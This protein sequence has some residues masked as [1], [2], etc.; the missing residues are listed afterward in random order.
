MIFSC[1]TSRLWVGFLAICLMAATVHCNGEIDNTQDTSTSA[2]ISATTAVFF[3]T[4]FSSPGEL[5]HT[6]ADISSAVL[7]SADNSALGSEATLVADASGR[8]IVVHSGFSSFSSDNLT[9]LDPE[10]A[11][12]VTGQFST[13]SDAE[14]ALTN[15]NSAIVIDDTAYVALSNGN[16]DSENL[17]NAGN[18]ADLLVMDLADGTFL[19]RISFLTFTED[20]GDRNATPSAMAQAGD[21]IY[22]ALQDLQSDYSITAPGKLIAVDTTT[23]T[24]SLYATLQ[25]TNPYDLAYSESEDCLVVA[26][27][28]FVNFSLDTTTDTGG[29]ELV[30]DGETRAFI[31]D[32]DLD[33]YPE[34]LAVSDD[35]DTVF[36]VVSKLNDD[37]SFTSKIVTF[38]LSDF[39]AG[40]VTPELVTF[41]APETDIRDMVLDS[42][43]KLWVATREITE[44]EGSAEDPAV[45]VLDS[46]TGDL[47]AQ[48]PTNLAVTAIAFVVASEN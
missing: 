5:S 21:T 41:F 43:N 44:G 17:D 31:N 33:G 12:S 10:D 45:V 30:C 29:I 11:F 8:L 26:A 3:S 48:Y 35:L 18:P 13:H 28:Y 32:D 19:D 25:G 46:S 1:N 7:E 9:L 2:D 27:T 20:D 22:V 38:S 40:E 14:S 23:N 36:A 47:L 6:P 24:A 16:Y 15:P 34:R 37:F 39:V 42:E 4:D